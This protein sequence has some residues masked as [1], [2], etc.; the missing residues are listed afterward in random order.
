MELKEAEG[1]KKVTAPFP[2]YDHFR[3]FESLD[4]KEVDRQFMDPQQGPKK[5]G[6]RF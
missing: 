6:E 3:P 1:G 2:L 4:P 5:V